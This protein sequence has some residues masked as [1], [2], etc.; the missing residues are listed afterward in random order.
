VEAYHAGAIRARLSEI[1]G[2]TVTDQISTLRYKLSGVGDL[3]VLNPGNPFTFVNDDVNALAQRRT[4]QQVLSIVYGGGTS[5]GLFYPGGM[6]GA[7]TVA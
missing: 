1:G 3:G 2:G 4:P 7:V 5:Y 6:N